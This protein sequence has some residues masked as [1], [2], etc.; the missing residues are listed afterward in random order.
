M[1]ENGR[2]ETIQLRINIENLVK[3]TNDAMI[4]GQLG[5]AIQLLKKG[6][7]VLSQKNDAY[8]IQAREKLQAMYDDLENNRRNKRSAVVEQEE[9]ERDDDLAALFGD[10]KKW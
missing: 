5:T 1:S 6:I 4:R 3:R 9:K 7:D 10:K 2:L 8:A